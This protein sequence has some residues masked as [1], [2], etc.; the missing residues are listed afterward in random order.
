MLVSISLSLSL[1][2]SLSPFVC[3]SLSLCLSLLPLSLFSLIFVLFLIPLIWHMMSLSFPPPILHP[4]LSDVNM[5]LSF[6]P[7][8]HFSRPICLLPIATG[9]REES[10]GE[11]GERTCQIDPLSSSLKSAI[12]GRA[13][14]A[15][16]Y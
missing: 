2:V 9:A 11:D 10:V 5:F 15:R 6:V 8:I 1:Y 16:Q 4:V 12:S 3:L 14:D 7:A 13:D